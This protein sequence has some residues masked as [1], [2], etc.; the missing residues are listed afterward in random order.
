MDCVL[1]RHPY[2]RIFYAHGP[3]R[4]IPPTIRRVHV[5]DAVWGG[6]SLLQWRYGPLD[7]SAGPSS[8]LFSR[9]WTLRHVGRVLSQ[10]ATD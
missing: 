10:L 1:H 4:H 2:L 9:Y 3:H 6:G 8:V 5:P 7:A